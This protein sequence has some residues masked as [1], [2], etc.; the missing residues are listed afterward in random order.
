MDDISGGFLYNANR[1]P[2][3]ESAG[4][5]IRRREREAELAGRTFAHE[6]GQGY[7]PAA[8]PYNNSGK[9]QGYAQQSATRTS[10]TRTSA[11][12]ASASRTSATRPASA[13][14]PD[15]KA[16]QASAVRDGWRVDNSIEANLFGKKPKRGW[17]VGGSY[18]AKDLIQFLSAPDITSEEHGPIFNYAE[19]SQIPEK[20]E[21]WSWVEISLSAI[22]NNVM[23]IRSALR[24]DTALMAVVKADGYG[25][26]AVPVA[27]TAIN[28]GANYLGVATVDEAVE[29]RRGGIEAPILVLSEPSVAS[30]PLLLGYRIMPSIASAEFAVKYAE[31]ADVIGMRA[32]FHLKINTGMNRVGVRSEQVV[33]FLQTISFH[34]ALEL[35]GTFT[36]FATADAQDNMDFKRQQHRF[37]DAIANMKAAGYDPGIIHAA[38]SA[39]TLRYP[40]VHYDMV[41]VGLAIYGYYPCLETFGRV[42]LLPAMS[43]KA[44]ITQVNQVP[45][46]EGVSY[47]LWHRSGGF[48]KTC[49]IPLGYADGLRRNLSGRINFILA[50]RLHPQVGSICMDQCMFEV[51]QRTRAGSG[52]IEPQVGDEVIIVGAQG[53]AFITLDEMAE[54]LGTIPYEIMIGFGISRLPRIYV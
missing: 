36:H 17:G 2:D 34:R 5:V 10:A 31:A 37:E 28:S 46:G 6:A 51:D 30:I 9:T 16:A 49:T 25:H 33:N 23:S 22:Q 19:L 40:E 41:R 18:Q 27:K 1:P 35:V 52:K 47:G 45:L 21:R 11:S 14:S 38:N 4:D 13:S 42:N 53:N 26:G 8:D 39:A 20:D 7:S 43:V 44:R 12:N 24:P 29:L 3:F 32:P 54:V 50:G 48:A 15:I